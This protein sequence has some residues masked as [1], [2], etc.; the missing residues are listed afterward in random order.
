MVKPAPKVCPSCPNTFTPRR[1]W[2]TYCTR[3]CQ[4]EAYN[5]K[6]IGKLSGMYC[7]P[8]P[9][10]VEQRRKYGLLY[11]ALEGLQIGASEEQRK[12]IQDVLDQAGNL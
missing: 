11:G 7:C 9:E 3:R 8:W 12:K 6:Q 5:T 1:A 10:R 4:R 2:Q